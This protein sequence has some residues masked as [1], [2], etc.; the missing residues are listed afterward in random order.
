M[1]RL[2]LLREL[3]AWSGRDLPPEDYPT[4]R[5]I[6]R[7]LAELAEADTLIVIL[8]EFQ[9]LMGRQDDIVSQLAA[10]WDREVR[11]R[12]LIL[13]LSGSEV[14]TM[15]R[16]Q[17]GD[18]PLYG[19]LNWAARIRP[20]DYRDAARMLPRLSP[21]QAALAFGI[22]GGTPRYLAAIGD[23]HDLGPAV[24]QT[25]LSPRGE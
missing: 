8:D 21:R 5:T 23:A 24:S 13:A 15:E 25:M 11:G 12:P 16:L 10:V 4:W 17:A 19:R 18:Q 3:S 2:D 7:L 6:F 20:F 1:N 14:A 9:Y 22:V